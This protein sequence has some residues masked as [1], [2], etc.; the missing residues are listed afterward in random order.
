MFYCPVWSFDNRKY[1]EQS[2]ITDK[3]KISDHAG[4]APEFNPRVLKK[5]LDVSDYFDLNEIVCLETNKNCFISGIDK[6]TIRNDRIYIL[7]REAKSLFLFD[8]K[9]KFISKIHMVG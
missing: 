6:M 8:R 1:P 7:D 4:F 9:G 3:K 5:G 2:S